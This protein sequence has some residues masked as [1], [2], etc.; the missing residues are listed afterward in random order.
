MTVSTADLSRF[1]RAGAIAAATLA[2]VALGVVPQ[3]RAEAATDAL[4]L[5]DADLTEVRT[6]RALA[7]GVTLTHIERGSVPAPADQIN[8]TTRGP[9]VV[10]VLTIDPS[11]ARGHLKATYGPDLAKVEKTTDLVR[12]SGALAGVNA[13]FFTFTASQLYPGDPVGLGLF[14]GKL[15]SEPIGGPAEVNFV[16]DANSNRALT[17][18]L[19]WSGSVRNRQTDATLPLEFINHPPVVPAGC[20]ALADQTQCTLPGDVVE[21][22]PEFA[23][24][25]PSGVGVE[26]VLDRLGCVVRT[27]TTRGTTLAAGQTSLQATGR[28]TAA[29]LNVTAQGCVSTTSTLTD[30]HGEELPVRPG[31][32]GVTGRYPLTAD[33]QIVVPDGSGSFFDRNPRTIAG[34]TRDGKIVLATIDGRQTTS[35]GTTMDETAAVAQ[36]LGMS[37]AVNLDGGGSTAMSV[38]GALINRPSGS[39]ERAVG[40]ALVYVDGPYRSGN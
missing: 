37:D 35:V 4:P 26:V 39:T 22:T 20:A 15:L 2:A 32:F 23:A 5:G 33:G 3:A 38:E 12:A 1:R 13:S 21:F 10:N 11:K 19:T 28:D 29:L 18:K 36:A 25:T 27:S 17:G 7:D 14:G 24:S 40:D 6:T 8:T 9:W 31:L 16:V 34:T 30:Q